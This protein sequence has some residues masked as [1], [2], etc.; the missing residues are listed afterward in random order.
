MLLLSH[1][2]NSNLLQHIQ[3][4]CL[5][6]E[7][8][9]EK[10]ICACHD[11][12]KATKPWQDYII[13]NDGVS[14][15][16][17]AATGGL[18][19]AILIRLLDRPDAKIWSLAALH[20]GGAHHSHLGLSANN[21]AEFCKIGDDRQAEYFFTDKNCGIP[22]ILP[23]V[24]EEYFSKAWAKFR[25]LAPL[26]PAKINEFNNYWEIPFDQRLRA[27]LAARAILARLCFQDH[28]SA[29][30][31][32]GKKESVIS[33]SSAYPE[34][35]FRKRIPKLF[36][37]PQKKIHQL[38]SILK[39]E[40][41]KVVEENSL[42]YFI[43]APTGLGKTETMLSAA[44][45]LLEKHKHS[46]I[47]FAVPQI[48]IADQIFEEYFNGNDN[49]QIWN[50]IR[51]E[52]K[53]P[54]KNADESYRDNDNP[55]FNL[56][57]AV[58]P[59]SESYNITTFNQVLMAMCHPERERCIRG[60]GLKNAIIIMDEFHKL[61]LCILPYFFRIANAY[62]VQHK[63]R[64]I[65]GSATPL[66]EF[67]YLGLDGTGRIPQETSVGIYKD[68]AIDN[69]RQY[70][71]IGNL[72]IDALIEKI[73]SF[74]DSSEKNLLV[75]LNLI[76]EGTWPLLKAFHGSYNPWK[77][78][79]CLKAAES[80]RSII[81]LDGL[82]P[83][84]LR[85]QI[86]RACKEI[87]KSRPVTLIS[88]QMIEVGVDLDFDHAIIDYQGLASIIQRGGRAGREGR[89][90]P[91]P[92]E[93][94]SLITR[95]SKSSFETLSDIVL[96]NDP[97][98]GDTAFADITSKLSEF[99]RKERRFFSQW[100]NTGLKD[101]DLTAKLL[102]IQNKIFLDSSESGLNE[103]LDDF[104]AQ[105]QAAGT[106]G[107]NFLQAQYIAELFTSDYGTDILLL[108]DLSAMEHIDSLVVKIKSGNPEKDDFKELN[109]FIA[110]RKISI[111]ETLLPELALNKV[112]TIDIKD[113]LQCMMIAGSI[114]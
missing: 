29:A 49:A 58:Q 104:F 101:S 33:W 14:P 13:G 102:E 68:N 111:S 2:R 81:F 12:G 108:E 114:L 107:C 42:F 59:F 53:M 31:Q 55:A 47:I 35:D 72:N 113:N 54:D 80:G 57:T 41:H 60:L 70:I 56:E 92:I 28:E 23:E 48:S 73:E 4:V 32:S 94:F 76:G 100:E 40:F 9:E 25:D 95:E 88:T 51:R 39:E 99:W 62:A 8:L 91:C 43:D 6:A 64:F 86:I 78:L 93:V 74:H 75:V 87:M 52:K 65:F 24:Q 89:D 44:E 17:H 106:L 18:L 90:T 30:K 61:P 96:Q 110:D 46:K 71:N 67:Q 98:S 22:S 20:A 37:P 16:H 15:H 103:M 83:P 112:G 69:R 1:G 7:N 38:R 63:C 50:Y 34:K 27:F 105:S 26:I 19:A 21:K 77:Q 11:L 97:R 109:K 84:I 79:D 5:A 45:K 36:P 10:I 66:E 82:V 3:E 85:R